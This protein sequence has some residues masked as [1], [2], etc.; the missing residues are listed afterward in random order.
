MS[1]SKCDFF[2]YFSLGLTVVRSLPSGQSHGV[3]ENKCAFI[4][5][6]VL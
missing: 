4:H 5:I 3:S 2:S 1:I 6:H